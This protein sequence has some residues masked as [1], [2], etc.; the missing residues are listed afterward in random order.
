MMKAPTKN[1][2]I[3]LLI[4]TV[5]TIVTLSFTLARYWSKRFEAARTE[6]QI[7]KFHIGKDSTLASIANNLHYFGFIRDENALTYA[8]NHTQ[9]T[10]LGRE[11]AISIGNKTINTETDYSISQ[12]MTA[13]EIASI[14]L[15]K[16]EF[17]DCGNGCSGMFY[18][19]LLPG[20][21]LTPSPQEIYEWVKTF[22]DCVRAKGQLSSEQYSQRTGEPRKCVSPDGREFIQGVGGW[23]KAVGG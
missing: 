4:L 13:W 16:G 21:D 6:S 23:R 18:P 7:F 10:T 15:N 11:G 5:T 9:D 3:L 17:N 22:E 2:F 8:I 20:G 12:N 19:A 14:L 1:T